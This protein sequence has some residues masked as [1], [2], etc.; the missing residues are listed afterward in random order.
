MS[1]AKKGKPKVEGSGKPSQQIEVT[2]ITNNQT[3]IYDSIS[4]AAK[5]LNILQAVITR[6]FSRNQTKPYKGKYTFKKL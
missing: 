2:D 6:Y 1:E 3:T 4:A 5:A